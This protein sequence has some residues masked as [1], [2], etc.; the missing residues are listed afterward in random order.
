MTMNILSFLIEL[1]GW[2]KIVLSPTLAAALIAGLIL[3][4][5]QD[6]R[7]ITIALSVIAIGFIVGVVWAVFIWRKYGTIN[8]LSRVSA[9]PELDQKES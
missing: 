8:F 5:N 1:F 2:V 7:G 4:N 6:E 9:T 3:Y